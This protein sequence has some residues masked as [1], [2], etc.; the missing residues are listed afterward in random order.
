MS[1][2]GSS[3]AFI[4]LSRF[5]TVLLATDGVFDN[6][7]IDEIV[8]H[9]RKGPLLTGVRNLLTQIQ[10]RMNNSSADTASKPDHATLIAYRA[11]VANA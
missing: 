3:N 5:D 4:R 11:S 10:S 8:S 2:G 9:L 1:N 7:T 6:L